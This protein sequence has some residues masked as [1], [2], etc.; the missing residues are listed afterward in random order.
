MKMEVR[1]SK[2]FNV[3]KYYVKYKKRLVLSKN[4]LGFRLK[5]FSNRKFTY[6]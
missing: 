1:D 5:Y 3:C 4:Y 6:N 2:Y